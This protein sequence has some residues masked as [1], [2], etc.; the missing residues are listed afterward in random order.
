MKFPPAPL[1]AALLFCPAAFAAEDPAAPDAPGEAVALFD[2]KGFEGWFFAPHT[3]P[4]AIAA[5]APAGRAAFLEKHRAEGLKHWRVEP[6][7]GGAELVNDGEGPYLWTDRDFADFELSLDWMIEPGTDSGV[8]VRGCPQVQ[9]WDPTAPDPRG[10]GNRLGSG[11]LWNNPKAGPNSRGKDPAVLADEPT[12]QWNK[13][14][15]RVVG[16]SVT[17]DLNGQRVVNEARLENYWDRSLPLFPVGPIILQTHGGETRWRNVR[18]REI[19]RA[20]PESGFLIA[21]G[22]PYGE[23]WD[24]PPPRLA[25]VPPGGAL[26]ATI[27]PLGDDAA[28]LVSLVRT[29][30]SPAP[31]RFRFSASGIEVDNPLSRVAALAPD[32][33]PD[34]AAGGG[35]IPGLRVDLPA[36]EAAFAAEEENRLFASNAVGALTLYMNGVP[37]LD[38]VAAEG[39]AVGANPIGVTG[40]GGLRSLRWSDESRELSDSGRPTPAPDEAGF[41]PVPLEPGLPGWTGD[42]A[43]Y[44]V[45]LGVLTCEGGG[46]VYFPGDHGDFAVRFEFRLPPGGNNGVGLRAVRGENAAYSGMESQILDNAAPRYAGIKPWQAHGS[47]YGVVPALRGYLAPVGHWNAQEIRAVGDRV[48]VTL[49]GKTIVDADLREAIADGAP[50]GEPHAGLLRESGAAGFLGHGAP[51]AW[52]NVRLKDLSAES[53]ADF[54]ADAGAGDAGAN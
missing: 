34:A 9:I 28:D 36:L 29:G 5:M 39:E 40:R 41:I 27:G 50:D 16:E 25:V 2:G 24:T 1:L 8:Y 10:N 12:G 48:T 21:N 4:R 54:D 51:V 7:D 43:G 20:M 33:P 52:R 19:P 46:N 47:I 32:G 53:G 31:L 49:N 35:P 26:H 13:F 44:G 42:T 14:V 15:V 11:G 18:V 30:A 22:E 6:G 45:N 38:A 37:F 17:V 23:G 3:D